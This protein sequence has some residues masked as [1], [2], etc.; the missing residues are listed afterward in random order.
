MSVWTV[1]LISLSDGE[2]AGLLA[3]GSLLETEERRRFCPAESK[4]L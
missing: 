3:Y 4:S 2:V 1:K